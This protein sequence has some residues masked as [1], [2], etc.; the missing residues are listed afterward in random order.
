M[1]YQ[2]ATCQYAGEM[3]PGHEDRVLPEA[4]AERPPLPGDV[5]CFP[6]TD[7]WRDRV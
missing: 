1:T 5:L 7:S 6:A 2:W 4:T 3:H